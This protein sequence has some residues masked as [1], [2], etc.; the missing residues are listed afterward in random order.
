MSLETN[1]ICKKP[2]RSAC[3]TIVVEA[4]FMFEFVS[5]MEGRFELAMLKFAK[6]T[7]HLDLEPDTSIHFRLKIFKWWLFPLWKRER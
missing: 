1:R 6:S 5:S 7:Q 4:F 2:S 3:I